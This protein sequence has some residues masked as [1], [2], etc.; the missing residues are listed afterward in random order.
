MTPDEQEAES[1]KYGWGVIY[2]LRLDSG[3]LAA[4]NHRRQLVGIYPTPDHAVNA[5]EAQAISKPE[6]T[7][8]P[9]VH[10]DLSKYNL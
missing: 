8:L 9:V 1:H 5:V 4:F 2:L 7:T 3:N 6:P 10:L